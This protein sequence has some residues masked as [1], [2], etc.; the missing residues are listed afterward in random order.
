MPATQTDRIGGLTTS[1]AVKAPVRVA[2]TGDN[3]V[4]AGLQVVDSVQLQ[5]G[6]GGEILADRVLVKDQTDPVEN[7]IYKVST[8]NWA[9]AGD[10]DGPFDVVQGTLVYVVAGEV[11]A[12]TYFRVTS[13]DPIYFDISEIIFDHALGGNSNIPEGLTDPLVLYL[14]DYDEYRETRDTDAAPTIQGIINS[15]PSG[16]AFDLVYPSGIT[17]QSDVSTNGRTVAFIG[18]GSPLSTIIPVNMTLGCFNIGDPGSIVQG[19]E[20]DDSTHSFDLPG[21]VLPGY[22]LIS[23]RYVPN[24][25][26]ALVRIGHSNSQTPRGCTVRDVGFTWSRALGVNYEGGPVLV[27]DSCTFGQCA[28]GGLWIPEG[29]GD[30]NHWKIRN[31]TFT[32]CFNFNFDLGGATSNSGGAGSF[33]DTKLYGGE[34]YNG[35]INGDANSG[36]IFVELANSYRQ[37]MQ[38]TNGS[39]TAT[40]PREQ[41]ASI[42]KYQVFNNN[43]YMPNGTYVADLDK[44]AGTVTLSNAATGTCPANTTFTSFTQ[45]GMRN[46]SIWISSTSSG[47]DIHVVGDTLDPACF[48]DDSA[49]G[50][51]NLT[52]AVST[53]PQL[54]YDNTAFKY[55]VAI[56]ERQT[57]NPNLTLNFTCLATFTA[58]SSDF[59]V[60]DPLVLN[61]IVYGATVASPALTASTTV[62]SVTVGTSTVTMAS[63]GANTVGTGTFL[64]NFRPTVRGGL[65]TKAFDDLQ[66]MESVSGTNIAQNKIFT[67]RGARFVGITDGTTTFLMQRFDEE[68]EVPANGKA[69]FCSDQTI[70]P[71]GTTISS[72]TGPDANGIYTVILSTAALLTRT[73][74]RVWMYN[75]SVGQVRETKPCLPVH[76]NNAT[77]LSNGRRLGEEYTTPSGERRWVVPLANTLVL[78]FVWDPASIAI[79]ASELSPDATVTGA[80]TGDFVAAASTRDL[81]GMSLSGYVSAANTVKLTLTNNTGGAIN[82][83]STT[84]HIKVTKP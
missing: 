42:S 69:I 71:D 47:N 41:M 16:S 46:P 27:I 11:F 67:G 74:V 5:G 44:N 34:N 58:G 18:K 68:T 83:A 24:D 33:E 77:A 35:R 30:T 48:R 17:Y 3:I 37:L 50:S 28:S 61:R 72:F 12:D 59:V 65:L 78:D 56:Q 51:N 21:F 43:A 57:G 52:I 70:I 75:T 55:R 7:G 14:E 1:V 53:S 13:A 60:S 4:L 8:G 79:N 64:V 19:F 45:P 29:N 81:Q 10:F 25:Q 32:G 26:R 15:L 39:T 9:R 54:V 40:M 20:I 82:L 63:A 38:T 36:S 80:A 49:P 2:T 31:S 62:S 76:N 23:G 22:T 84:F 73:G 6:N 66:I